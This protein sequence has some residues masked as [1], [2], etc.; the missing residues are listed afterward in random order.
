MRSLHGAFPKL[1]IMV[2]ENGM[3]TDNGKPHAD[4]YTRGQDLQDTVYWLQ[5][6]RAAGVPVIGYLYW[7]LT[8]NYEFGS[9]RSRFG[10]YTVNVLKDPTLTRRPTDAVAPYR[11]IIKRGGVPAGYRL[12]RHT[13]GA[14]CAK[15]PV[16][17]RAACVGAER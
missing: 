10:L 8:D 11:A 9:Y 4:G 14:D 12:V 16:A 3:A 13:L 17:E 1:P 2:T 6:A 7:S 15:V 5:R